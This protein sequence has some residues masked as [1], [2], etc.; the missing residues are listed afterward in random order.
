MNYHDSDNNDVDHGYAK[1]LVA[2]GTIGA[3]L[4]LPFG[5]GFGLVWSL[6]LVGNSALITY[7]AGAIAFAGYSVAG[8]LGAMGALAYKMCRDKM[9]DYAFIDPDAGSWVTSILYECVRKLA[10]YET[11]VDF[12]NMVKKSRNNLV[13]A[14]KKVIN[15][16]TNTQACTLWLYNHDPDAPLSKNAEHLLDV[17]RRLCEFVATAADAIAK[18][19]DEVVSPSDDDIRFF[20][21]STT[22]QKL[23]DAL[24]L[25]YG[26]EQQADIMR[27]R[28]AA[29]GFV[30]VRR[31][32][33]QYFTKI[34]P[35]GAG[36]KSISIDGLYD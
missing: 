19:L 31:A 16:S 20:M 27:M 5:G 11:R 33:P 2:G 13:D 1:Y 9:Y 28:A 24:R 14:M 8:T 4:T 23:P 17:E 30:D 15:E 34:K 29:E 26:L 21:G 32:L 3:L 25:A 10:G 18:V 6:G 7:G 35:L 36:V 12:F 22:P